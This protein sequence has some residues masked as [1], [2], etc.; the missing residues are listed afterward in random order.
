VRGAEFELILIN[1]ITAARNHNKLIKNLAH[2]AR[3]RMSLAALVRECEESYM[4]SAMEC[5]RE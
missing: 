2:N 3:R 4:I 5:V 1:H